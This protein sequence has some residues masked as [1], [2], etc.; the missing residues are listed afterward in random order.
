MLRVEE[1]N[2]SKEMVTMAKEVKETKPAIRRRAELAPRLSEV[3]RI[4]EDWFEDLWSRPFPRLWRPDF[5]RLRPMRLEAPALDVYEEK[6]DLVVKAELPGL[7]KE[8]I[9]II[10]TGST[11]TIKGEKKKVEEIKE[12]DYYRCERSYGAFARSID[13]P[14]EVQAEKVKASYKDGVLEVRLPKT[15]ESKSNVVKVK[16]A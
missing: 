2:S 13:L 7:S 14:A 9:D 4:F 10:L 15:E 8:D 3:E 6:G 11:M 1:S 16:V 5:W 12:D